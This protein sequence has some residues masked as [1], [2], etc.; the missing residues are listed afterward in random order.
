MIDTTFYRNN[1]F[2][3]LRDVISAETI[4]SMREMLEIEKNVALDLIRQRIKFQD[5]SDLIGKIKPLLCSPNTGGDL[6]SVLRGQ[7]HL[8][9][10][11][12]PVLQG[13]CSEPKLL[14]ILNDLFENRA[15][16]LHMPPMAR[17]ILPENYQ[18]ARPPHHDLLFNTHLEDF[19]IAWVPL[20]ATDAS[21]GGMGIYE[22]VFK[23]PG[24][25]LYDPQS[26]WNEA[27]P[28]QGIRPTQ[29]PMNPGDIL[30]MSSRIVH[31]SMP[32]H[33]KRIRYSVDYRFFAEP[34][35]SSK[36]YLDLTSGEVLAP[37]S[38]PPPK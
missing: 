14:T 16:R 1:G 30:L 36:H 11:L 12:N 9:A 4:K 26:I 18:A 37:S 21:C 25:K 8:S 32:N 20:V 31:C 33:S 34:V 7:Y 28:I 10:R 27:L 23:D 24:I 13:I 5:E 19:V 22:G 6:A 17:F 15:L 3:F 29:E 35:R 38:P 2:Q